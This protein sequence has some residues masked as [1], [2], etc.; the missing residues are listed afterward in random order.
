L[1]TWRRT[2][3][4]RTGARRGIGRGTLFFGF[5]NK[6]GG[7]R[8]IRNSRKRNKTGTLINVYLVRIITKRFWDRTRHSDDYPDVNSADLIE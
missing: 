1:R 8:R 5:N 6:H 7:S 2:W 4:P 3:W